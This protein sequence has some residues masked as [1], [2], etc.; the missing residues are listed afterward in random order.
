VEKIKKDAIFLIDGSAFLYRAYYAMRPLYTSKG[1][2]VQAVF[3]FCRTIKRMINEFNPKAI[4]LV[5]DSKGETFR[6]EIYPQYKATRQPPPSDLM[7]QKARVIEFADIINLQQTAKVGY[8]ADDLIASLAAENKNNQVVVVTPDKDLHQLVDD[9]VIVFD[10][11]KRILI[12][13]E[14]FVENKNFQPKELL[15]YHALLGDASDNIP[16]VRGIG[17]KTAQYLTENFKTL[18]NL[19]ENLD[20][21]EKDRIRNLLKDQKEQAYLS[22]KLFKLKILNLGIGFSDLVFDKNNWNNAYDFF[23]QLEFS[24]FL[25]GMKPLQKQEEE[26]VEQVFSKQLSITDAILEP[27]K[28]TKEKHSKKEA[29]KPV[30]ALRE[31]K[32]NPWEKILIDDKKALDDLISLL[33]KA[34][35]FAI[36]TET[37]GVRPLKDELVGISFAFDEEKAYYIPVAHETSQKQLGRSYTLKKLKP[38]LE[39]KKLKKIL[40]NAKFDRLIFWQYGIDVAGVEFDTMLAAGL[41]R[42]EGRKIGLKF[43]SRQY[44]DEEML[45]FEDVTAKKY[46]TFAQVPIDLA[47][48]YGA[49]DSLQ[50][51]KLKKVLEEKLGKVKKLKKL[52][53]NMEMPLADVLFKMEHNGIKLNVG[54]VEKLKKEVDEDLKIIQGKILANIK[55]YDGDESINLNSP[56]QV[57]K[58]LF[59]VLELPVIKKSSEGARSTDQEVLERLSKV[60]P[61]PGLLLQYRELFKLKSTYL[62]PLPFYVNEKTKRVHTTFG[63]SDVATGRLSSYKPNLQNIPVTSDYGIKIRSAFEAARGNILLSV[64]Y[65]QIDLRVLAHVT[66]DK[67]L[68]NAF[69][70]GEDIHI[71]T[72]AEIFGVPQ[73]KVTSKQRQVGKR[74]NFSIIYGLTPFG[75]SKDL[76]IK[77]SEA[78]IYIEKYFAK[79]PGVAK[80]MGEVVEKAKE[81]G[82]VETVFGRRRYVSAIREKNKIVFESAKRL[83]INTPI[84][85]T[86]AEVIKLAM[87]EIDKK[88]TKK[89]LE[90]KM[91]LQIHDEL[92]FEVPKSEEKVAEKIIKKCME[93]VLKW[94]I[95]LVISSKK[96]KNWMQISK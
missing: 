8:E 52:F 23:S 32:Q 93:N 61:I 13:Q 33:K 62:E 60:H 54:V 21:V 58:L 35:V 17:K 24:F 74:I 55:G 45:S 15:L 9:R 82:F 71:Q 12:D 42:L 88:L 80:W 2:P 49:H 95:P 73:E 37:T 67:T 72:A 44:L 81:D 7:G 30:T 11:I 31:V 39:N 63:Q 5:W 79:Y 66:K 64:D 53:E 70:K 38:L 91:L 1:E 16:G 92:I 26:K 20:Q 19:Y 22:R 78:K 4:S 46:K 77:P 25:R 27:A 68:K 69:L 51:F 43:L 87:I 3:G 29:Q 34:K 86:S 57:E 41:L 85:G 14:V 47:T 65:S 50:T 90:T 56:K 10:P 18:D 36:D 84:Q 89:K 40:Q 96:G 94:E 6:N 83:T 76:D 48:R 75:L 59:D 28:K